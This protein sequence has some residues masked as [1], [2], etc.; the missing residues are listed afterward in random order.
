MT[1][2]TDA[3][4]NKLIDDLDADSKSYHGQIAFYKSHQIV[5]DTLPVALMHIYLQQ[6]IL[7]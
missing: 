2:K 5:S 6:L 3:F 7:V 4:P 1:K